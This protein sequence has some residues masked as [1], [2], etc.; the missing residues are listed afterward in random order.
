VVAAGAVLQF[1]AVLP[2]NDAGPAGAGATGDEGDDSGLRAA[3]VAGLVFQLHANGYIAGAVGFER[4][5]IGSARNWHGIPGAV[6]GIGRT[7]FDF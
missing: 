5:A 2:D 6:D 1:G 4:C 7:V 3:K